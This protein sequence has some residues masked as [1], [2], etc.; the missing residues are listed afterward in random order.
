MPGPVDPTIP[1]TIDGASLPPDALAFAG[2][3]FEAARTGQLALFQQ[4]LPAG[5]PANLTN[6]RGDTLVGKTLL[7]PPSTTKALTGEHSSC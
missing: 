6:D 1:S 4:A 2:R 5:L 3:M 7:L